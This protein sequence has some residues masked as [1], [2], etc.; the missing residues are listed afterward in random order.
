[1]NTYE[2][3]IITIIGIILKDHTW[4]RNTISSCPVPNLTI[5]LSMT[6]YLSI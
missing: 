6:E 3:L 5:R 2:M 1:M 4:L